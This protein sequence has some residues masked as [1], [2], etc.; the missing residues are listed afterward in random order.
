MSKNNN[1]LIEELQKFF[2]QVNKVRTDVMKRE[3]P[4][5][6]YQYFSKDENPELII[7]R[8]MTQYEDL[9]KKFKVIEKKERKLSRGSENATPVKPN[10]V[11]ENEDNK[12]LDKKLEFS[13]KKEI[14]DNKKEEMKIKDE[15]KEEK[16]VEKTEENNIVVFDDFEKEPDEGYEHSQTESTEFEITPDIK[17][18]AKWYYINQK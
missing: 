4:Y 6:S 3:N 12:K 17:I 2:I 7:R 8:G 5:D 11:K 15:K 16:K 1:K 13:G 18:Y 10:P 9:V 14:K